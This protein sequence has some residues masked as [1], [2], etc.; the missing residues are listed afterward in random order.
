M[1]FMRSVGAG[2][3]LLICLAHGAAAETLV[4]PEA[5]LSID[6]PAGTY[7]ANG[8]FLAT[9]D[10]RTM[11]QATRSNG[12][13]A[14]FFAS[15]AS[16]PKMTV[17]TAVG[18]PPS[19]SAQRTTNGNAHGYCRDISDNN[20]F[21]LIVISRTSSD[22][23]LSADLG[24][25]IAA[26]EAALLAQG[27]R[28]DALP[29]MRTMTLGA[30]T[31]SLPRG[32]FVQDSKLVRATGSG[33][34]FGVMPKDGS[35]SDY[36]E[37]AEQQTDGSSS[38]VSSGVGGARW[39]GSRVVLDDTS[40]YCRDRTGGYLLLIAIGR[41][42][43][44]EVA[45][46]AHAI[47]ESY[48]EAAAPASS[49][50]PSSSSYTSPS[51]ET[52]TETATE[53]SS[54]PPPSVDTHS[55][56][57]AYDPHHASFASTRL[58]LAGGQETASMGVDAGRTYLG[59]RVEVPSHFMFEDNETGGATFS[60]AVSAGGAGSGM[61]GDLQGG[62]GIGFAT[63][64]LMI[65]AQMLTGIDRV[66]GGFEPELGLYIGVGGY[67]RLGLGSIAVEGTAEVLGSTGPNE[68]R[69]AVNLLALG[70]HRLYTIGGFYQEW[71]LSG[72][73]IGVSI[74]TGRD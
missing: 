14:G 2:V 4:L 9:V 54:A 13:C 56:D 59:A 55:S 28:G 26:I 25:M 7:K 16:D 19:W 41:A 50:T 51:S 39:S 22:A 35:C 21:G 15:L 62:I 36:M 70:S 18:A 67:A 45:M 47:D 61:I 23:E 8:A 10:N 17:D 6:V 49:Y 38:V 11:F 3:L 43:S 64:D 24:P 58:R 12:D 42:T 20:I 44:A 1:V 40:F 34:S 52:A 31:V 46:I 57:D 53:P 63:S 48:G 33:A 69:Y 29:A 73:M 65:H 32:S 71:E 66:A 27:A 68:T 30:L 74:G 37:W 72:S 5:G 60:A